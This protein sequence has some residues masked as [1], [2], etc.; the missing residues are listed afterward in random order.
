M[1]WSKG[2]YLISTDKQKI[3]TG[4]VHDFLTHS[5][6]AEGISMEVVE[7][8][9]ENSLCFGV[10]HSGQLV[11]FARVISDF[12]TFAYL[13]DVFIVP[14]HR[15]KGLSKQLLQVIVEYPALQN[16]R[17]FVLATRD[18]HDL[19]AQFGFTAFDKP[20]RWMQ[21]HNPGVYKKN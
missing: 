18:A 2:E 9:I 13:A 4:I 3:N 20:E 15:G 6:W 21:R 5:Y 10:Y 11:G 16:L 17:R 12:T 1:N 8:S 14:A 7:Q 19:Y